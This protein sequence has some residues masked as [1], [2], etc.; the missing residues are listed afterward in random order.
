[1]LSRSVLY[2]E[3]H[4]RL[5]TR[6]RVIEQLR[7]ADEEVVGLRFADQRGT[8]DLAR[9][10]LQGPGFGRIDEVADRAA[11]KREHP[12]LDGPSDTSIPLHHLLERILRNAASE[13]RG[14]PGYR[15]RLVTEA[16]RVH[17]VIGDEG[18][19]AVLE[20]SGARSQESP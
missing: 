18:R 19:E 16:V 8:L 2:G 20:G 17:A 5:R 13:Q 14:H 9:D 4:E 11:A 1:M 15:S 3:A 12:V 7:L 6:Q 10:T